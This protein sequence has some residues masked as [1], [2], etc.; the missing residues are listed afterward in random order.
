MHLLNLSFIIAVG[1]RAGRRDTE[2]ANKICTK[3][4]TGI[5]GVAAE[6]IH[7]A[8]GLPGGIEGAIRTLELHP[9]FN[10]AHT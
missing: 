2:L 6:R 10:P 5:A 8:L 9:L 4:L 3:Q 1:K 7:R